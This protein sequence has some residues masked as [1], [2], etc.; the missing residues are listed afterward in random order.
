MELL[1]KALQLDPNS[2]TAMW[3]LGNAAADNGDNTKAVDYWQQGLPAARRRTGDAVGTGADDHAGRW[4][5]T[6]TDRVAAADH[7]RKA[8]PPRRPQVRAR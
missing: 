5:A 2:V 6:G 1:E 7:G 8:L 3:L 4:P